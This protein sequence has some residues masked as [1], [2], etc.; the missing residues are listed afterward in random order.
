M[1]VCLIIVYIFFAE[2]FILKAMK[3]EFKKFMLLKHLK[4]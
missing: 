2:L 3:D 4:N 1:Y